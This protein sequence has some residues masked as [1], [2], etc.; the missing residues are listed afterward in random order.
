MPTLQLYLINTNLIADLASPNI[1]IISS[2]H[3]FKNFLLIFS[4]K[5]VFLVY[6]MEISTTCISLQISSP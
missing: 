5:K 4:T 6:I 2:M 1:L 3:F